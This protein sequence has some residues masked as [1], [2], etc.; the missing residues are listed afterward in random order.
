MISVESS[1]AGIFI[2]FI[3]CIT[4]KTVP[5]NYLFL[6][7]VLRKPN[8][9]FSISSSGRTMRSLNFLYSNSNT[10]FLEKKLVEKEN[11][12]KRETK[13][14]GAVQPTSQNPVSV[15]ILASVGLAV[16]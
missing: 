11:Q 1:F 14:M 13:R 5:L 15:N 9:G 2:K 12:T 3:F 10:V 6:L 7:L 8:L 4:A 16:L